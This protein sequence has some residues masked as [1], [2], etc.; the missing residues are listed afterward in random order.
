MTKDVVMQQTWEDF[1]EAQIEL[2]RTLVRLSHSQELYLHHLC[3][4]MED[5]CGV[6][7]F[8]QQMIFVSPS[9][10]S[11][12]GYTPEEFLNHEYIYYVHPDDLPVTETAQSILYDGGKLSKFSNRYKHKD[13]HYVRLVWRASADL[14]LKRIFFIAKEAP[15]DALANP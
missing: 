4:L 10:K 11:V 14:N 13:G 7:D 2:T 8:N 1:E 5:I 9:I 15:I 6:S 3:N 12:L